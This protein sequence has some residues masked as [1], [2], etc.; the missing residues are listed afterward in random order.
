MPVPVLVSP[1]VP[2]MTPDR[3]VSSLPVMVSVNPPFVIV[4]LV[5]T[6]LPLFA[7]QPWSAPRMMGMSI[8]WSSVSS[9][10]MACVMPPPRVP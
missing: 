4:V 10:T 9:L 7:F 5:I 8:V 2:D 3:L 1:P 6:R